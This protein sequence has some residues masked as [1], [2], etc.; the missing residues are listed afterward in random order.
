LE[1]SFTISDIWPAHVY[2]FLPLVALVF[3]AALFLL[4][5]HGG[6]SRVPF[7]L[8]V[9]AL[10]LLS[11]QS[12]QVDYQY[13]QDLRETGGRRTP[14]TGLGLFVTAEIISRHGGSIRAVPRERGNSFVFTLKKDCT[15]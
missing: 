11:A 10:A 8:G 13:H 3:G 1:S 15:K 4:W 2:M 7:A 5:R 9:A 6:M 14:G 12:L